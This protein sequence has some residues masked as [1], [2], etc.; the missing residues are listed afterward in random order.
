MTRRSARADEDITAELAALRQDVVRLSESIS[1]LLQS[2]AQGG[3]PHVSDA[4]DDA[5]AK[6]VSTAADVTSRVN[7]AGGE[8]EA[9]IER[10]PMT[11]A[12][13]SFGVGMAIGMMSRS[14]H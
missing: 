13:I 10:N 5:K 12:L 11:A 4:F 9:S 6:L 2:H 8:I 14:R 7:S 1:A 3:T